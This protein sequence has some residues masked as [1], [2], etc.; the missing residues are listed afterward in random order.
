MTMSGR[1]YNN[2]SLYRYGFN[3]KENDKDISVGGQDYGMR[4]YDSRIGKFLS[5]DPIEREYPELTPYQFAS[6]TPIEAID[7]DG[8]ECD[9][10]TVVYFA[11]WLFSNDIEDIKQG[12]NSVYNGYIKQIETNETVS[13]YQEIVKDRNSDLSAE[14]WGDLRKKSGRVEAL[15]GTVQIG[16]GVNSIGAKID[17]AVNLTVGAVKGVQA[18]SRMSLPKKVSPLR[19]NYVEIKTSQTKNSFEYHGMEF[20]DDG[21]RMK[22]QPLNAAKGGLQL[23][24][25]VAKIMGNSYKAMG[26]ITVPIKNTELLNSLN[27]T[28][29]GN[30]V[31][32]YEAGMR[33]GA[34]IETHYFRNSTTGQV[35]DVK[36]KYNYWHQKAFKTIGK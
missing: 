10:H 27:A 16:N 4:I 22:E 17:G 26:E 23:E 33:N 28:S 31:K 15:M 12:S 19:P 7:L 14:E 9:F 24:S 34:K 20:L 11:L 25:S 18:L 21:L 5:V 2:G 30:W 8:K 35:F 36:T 32:V 29:K 1:T 6:N 13:H 3:G